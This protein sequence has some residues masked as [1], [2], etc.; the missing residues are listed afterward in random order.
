MEKALYKF[1][2]LLLLLLSILLGYPQEDRLH[3]GISTCGLKLILTL[4]MPSVELT[5][6]VKRSVSLSFGGAIIPCPM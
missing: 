6:Q 3:G 1:Q 2:L 4:S 5:W